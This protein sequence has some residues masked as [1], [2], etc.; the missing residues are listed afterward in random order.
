MRSRFTLVPLVALA[1]ATACAGGE[2]SAPDGRHTVRGEIVRLPDPPG[3]ELYVRHESIPDF[4]DLSG[5]RVGMSSMT[6]PF[7]LDPGVDLAGLAAGD[8]VEM[9]FEVRWKAS[10]RPLRI[11][12]LERL[13]AG[14]R[15]EFDP[16]PQSPEAAAETPR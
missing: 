4:R 7:A 8:R 15:L 16:A 13:P 10:E 9:E 6:M 2:A 11:T 14:T 5:K 3:A 12:R 1:L